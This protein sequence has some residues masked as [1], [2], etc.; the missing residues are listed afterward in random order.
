[1]THKPMP[2]GT[3]ASKSDD[4]PTNLP[5]TH[6]AS[7]PT[8]DRSHAK[9]GDESVPG[10]CELHASSAPPKPPSTL[11][12]KGAKERPSQFEQGRVQPN[13]QS[14]QA[15]RLGGTM[16]TSFETRGLAQLAASISARLANRKWSRTLHRWHA[17]EQLSLF[18][19]KT[20]AIMLARLRDNTLDW[21][22]CAKAAALPDRSR[23]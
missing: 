5:T 17:G 3:T 9:A 19:R 16:D 7:S 2:L 23:P 1:V 21:E 12:Q 20:L 22:E 8:V 15:G 18:Q 4:V 10:M 13:K 14:A 6:E 11:L